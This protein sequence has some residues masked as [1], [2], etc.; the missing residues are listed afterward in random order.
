[1]INDDK[2]KFV[3][4]FIPCGSQETPNVKSNNLSLNKQ[5]R[6]ILCTQYYLK[7]KVPA[8]QTRPNHTYFLAVSDYFN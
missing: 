2:C 4:G 7:L 5:H 8:T 1:M 3:L 6:N